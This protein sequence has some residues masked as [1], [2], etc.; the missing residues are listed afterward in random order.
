MKKLI[1]TYHS[2]KSGGCGKW[3]NH[4]KGIETITCKGCGK[5]IKAHRGFTNP[6]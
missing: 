5:T 4:E 2:R 3:T 6:N 1:S